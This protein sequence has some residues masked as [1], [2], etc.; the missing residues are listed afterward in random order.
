MESLFVEI[1]FV[2]L[3]VILSIGVSMQ[4]AQ[5][6][7]RKSEEVFTGFLIRCTLS[8]IVTFFYESAYKHHVAVL[9]VIAGPGFIVKI[10]REITEIFR[11]KFKEKFKRD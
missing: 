1:S 2:L 7:K 11:S 5:I 10:V 6:F 3:L 4:E 8:V 9:I